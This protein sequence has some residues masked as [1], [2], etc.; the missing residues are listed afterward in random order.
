MV[1]DKELVKQILQRDVL[2]IYRSL[3][4]IG[5]QIGINITPFVNIFEDKIVGYVDVILENFLDSLF[6]KNNESDIDEV[7]D[8]AKMVVNDKIEEYRKKVREAKNLE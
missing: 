8:I 1:S 2:N 6:G 4:Q 7:S 3:P 5:N